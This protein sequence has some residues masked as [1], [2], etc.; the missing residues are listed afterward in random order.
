MDTG[1]NPWKLTTLG[2]ALVMATA[3]VAG[4]V[5][6][7]WSGSSPEFQP[8]RSVSA[9]TRQASPPRSAKPTSPQI[10]QGVPAVPAV[11][12]QDVVEACNRQATAEVGDHDMTQEG[13]KD[14]AIAAVV[15]VA[16]GA[17]GGAVA[18]GGKGAAIGGIVGASGGSLYGLNENRKND[19][20]FRAA[21][22]SCMR[23]RGYTA[24]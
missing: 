10:A 19:E 9:A 8:R 7:N 2:L 24:G 1:W 22:S 6:A 4:L 21:Y 15:G 17:P 23:S 3:L 18:A 14:A 11:P 20:K 12:T 16:V 5:V 13:V